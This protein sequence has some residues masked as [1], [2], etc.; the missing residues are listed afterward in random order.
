MVLNSKKCHFMCIGKDRE[1]ETFTFKDVCYK[2]SKEE[3]IL[4]ITIDNKLSFG[5]HIRK[6][7][8][9]SGQK[10]NA[11][12]RITTF[13]NKDKK[14]I[15]FNAMIKS[16]FS[17][18]PII[19]MFSSQRSNNLINKVHERSL[20][21][22]T[23]DENSSFETLLQNINDITVHQRNLQI[24]M[25]EVYKIIKGEAPAI[26]KNS[27]IFRENI[28]NIRNFQFIANENKNTVRYGLDTMCYRTPS[29]W[30]SLPEEYKHLNSVRK[31]KEKIKKWKSERCVCRLC[32]TYE[33]NLG[34]IFFF[35][36]IV[37]N[38]E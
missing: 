38:Q 22:I 20:R 2:S 23:N 33:Q 8:K 34:F 24:L 11:L 25:T 28:H 7:C 30:A 3:V 15:I 31:F 1:N 19:W 18:C 5:S 32:R 26:M 13:L 9:K 36:Q 16:K 14:S 37:F 17:Y 27:F 12:S 6:M 4:G 10:L 21:L 35:F 29:L